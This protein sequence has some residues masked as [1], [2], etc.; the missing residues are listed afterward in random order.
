[1]FDMAGRTIMQ[2]S[3]NGTSPVHLPNLAAGNYVYAI[4]QD[5]QTYRGKVTIR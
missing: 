3:W 4:R 5:E 2:Q 1:M